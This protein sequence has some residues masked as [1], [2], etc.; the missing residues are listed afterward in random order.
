MTAMMYRLP[1]TL[2]FTMLLTVA[3]SACIPLPIPHRA[4][5]TPKVSGVL[6]GESGSPVAG[7]RM[8]AARRPSAKDCAWSSGAAV[9]DST[10][11]FELPEVYVRKRILLVSLFESFGRAWYALC[12]R[13]ADSASTSGQP[14]IT[15]IDG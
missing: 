6:K 12:A 5:T 11:R 3:P 15:D 1:C 2:A 4:F 8:A 7:M 10:G 14:V 13:P 9:T